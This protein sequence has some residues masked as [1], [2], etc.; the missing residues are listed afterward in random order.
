MILAGQLQVMIRQPRSARPLG[1]VIRQL[2]T[3]RA[4]A[5]GVRPAH[6]GDQRQ[7]AAFESGHAVMWLKERFGIGADHA[8]IAGGGDG[9]DPPGE[10]FPQIGITGPTSHFPR[11]CGN[12][13]R[14]QVRTKSGFIDANHHTQ[15]LV[16]R[17]AD[18]E[19]DLKRDLMKIPR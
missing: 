11:G 10:T 18:S 7:D 3:Q 12:H 13:E 1:I 4:K 16:F 17:L 14:S 6:G 9:G 8:T 15:A 19:S 5:A 2:C